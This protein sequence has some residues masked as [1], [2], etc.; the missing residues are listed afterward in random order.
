MI[1]NLLFKTGETLFKVVGP[2]HDALKDS[3]ETPVFN[4]EQVDLLELSETPVMP[5]TVANTI[6]YYVG[7]TAVVF[8]LV[9]L[10]L[11]PGIKS[12]KP[13]PKRRYRRRKTTTRTRPVARRRKR[14]YKRRK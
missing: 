14:V 8:L 4:S 12:M 1:G 11:M 3:V 5:G 10:A 7:G 9:G 13:K 2:V 6:Y